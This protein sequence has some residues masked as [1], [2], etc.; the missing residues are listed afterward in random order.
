MM[1]FKRVNVKK[2]QQ[3]NQLLVWILAMNN[4]PCRRMVRTGPGMGQ[5][6]VASGLLN[7]PADVWS[8]LGQEWVRPG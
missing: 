1:K 4:R 3:A 7:E 8:G 2:V 5:A 6:R